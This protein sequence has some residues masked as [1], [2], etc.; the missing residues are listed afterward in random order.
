M[1]APCYH[2]RPHSPRLCPCYPHIS[3]ANESQGGWAS[4]DGLTQGHEME[5][6]PQPVPGLASSASCHFKHDVLMSLSPSFLFCRPLGVT[7]H[8]ELGFPC[9]TNDFRRGSIISQGALHKARAS[10]FFRRKIG[11]QSGIVNCLE[12][13]ARGKLQPSQQ[14][15][16]P[17]GS[18]LEVYGCFPVLFP[19]VKIT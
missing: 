14:N 11:L 19:L 5:E 2:L 15:H 9:P 3:C 6:L 4:R 17:R 12:D 8:H 10:E 13:W 1:G 16:P 18:W 7:L